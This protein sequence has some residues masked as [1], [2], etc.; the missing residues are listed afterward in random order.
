MEEAFL[1][2][3]VSQ[4]SIHGCLGR[5]TS[6]QTEQAK[7]AKGMIF[8][9]E[10]APQCPTSSNKPYLLQ[11]LP[12]PNSLI[13]FCILQQ[14]KPLIMSEPSQFSGLWKGSGR[15]TQNCALSPGPFSNQLCWQ[16]RLGI[17]NGSS[18]S[19]FCLNSGSKKKFLECKYYIFL[20]HTFLFL[21]VF[22]IS[23]EFTLNLLSAKWPWSSQPHFRDGKHWA[24]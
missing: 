5:R 24:S 1:C 17:T 14:I 16:S 11:F 22:I 23:S 12:P 3:T 9:S 18:R 20:K 10:T 15:H 19:L 6:W 8:T 7:R 4:V 2:F 21:H 13:Q